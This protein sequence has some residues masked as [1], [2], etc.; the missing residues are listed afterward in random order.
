MR[1]AITTIIILI[2]TITISFAASIEK[3]TLLNRHGLT[4]DAKRELI[5]VIFQ[6]GTT[7]KTK[8]KAYYLLGNI[9]FAE[10]KIQIALN[11]WNYLVEN[12][13]ISDEA[14]LVGDQIDELSEIVRSDSNEAI[15]NAIARSYLKNAEFWSKH[16]SDV[17]Q[18]DTSLIF[19][20]EV[21]LKWY[22]KVITEF[23]NSNAARMAYKG[24]LHTILA[25]KAFDPNKP[26]TIAEGFFDNHVSALAE[27]FVNFERE[28][29]DAPTLQ[30]F[31]YQIAQTYWVHHLRR[32]RAKAV[33][34]LELGRVWF[35]KVIQKAGTNDSFYRD[36]AQR[37]LENLNSR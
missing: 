25:S 21:A 27:T 34:Y 35:E 6:D 29:P 16:K 1:K 14:M 15:D 23:P 30:A 24:K 26:L 11:S 20:M 3:A 8:A 28:Y 12:Y 33:K 10:D 5:D 31:R 7:P 17:F 36:L 22:N 32:S 9:A 13:P 4:T 37:R 19:E 18:I 2:C